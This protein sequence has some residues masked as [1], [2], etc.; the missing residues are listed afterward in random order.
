MSYKVVDVLRTCGSNARDPPKLQDG[1]NMG[2][3]LDQ[4]WTPETSFLDTIENRNRFV[5]T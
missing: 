5:S 4:L 3:P 1:R 2:F